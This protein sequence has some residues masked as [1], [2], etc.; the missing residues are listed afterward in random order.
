MI[1]QSKLI[2]FYPGVYTPEEQKAIDE[3]KAGKYG[4]LFPRMQPEST[5]PWV[6]QLYARCW[7]RW[8]PLF[9]DPAYARESVWGDLPAIPG[10]ISMETRSSIPTELGIPARPDGT[11]FVGDGYDHTDYYFAPVFPGDVLSAK[12]TGWDLA[13]VT[14]PNGSVKRHIIFINEC[15]VYNQ[16]GE[17]VAR[18]VRRWPETLKKSNDEA[19]QLELWGD[20]AEDMVPEEIKAKLPKRSGPPGAPGGQGGPGAP[21]GAPAGGG[22]GNRHKAHVNTAEDYELLKEIWRGE[23]IRGKET[24]Y[25]ED[26]NIGD[27]PTPVAAPPQYGNEIFRT[28]AA[29]NLMKSNRGLREDLLEDTL[30]PVLNRL[31]PTT[32]LYG[33]G[34]SGHL[35]IGCTA[36]LFNFHAKLLGTRIITNWCGDEGFVTRLGWRFVND[37]PKDQQF[38]HFPENC[39]RPTELLKVPYMKDRYANIHGYGDDTFITRGYVYDKYIGEDGGH[40]VDLICWCEDLDGNIGQEIPATVRLPSRESK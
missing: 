11:S 29:W 20:A 30:D 35:G 7:D 13:D 21:G 40:Y 23:K 9:N 22:L 15:E 19:T 14:D 3:Y 5:D 27:E 8:N 31:D 24:L 33:T 17:L 28:I 36:Y 12:N 18:C 16:R 4:S 2:T 39:H 32:G 37:A 10:Y 34:M 25:W 26:V 1:D 6:M 38:N